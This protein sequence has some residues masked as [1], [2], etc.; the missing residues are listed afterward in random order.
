MRGF[1]HAED[2]FLMF[3]PGKMYGEEIYHHPFWDEIRNGAIKAQPDMHEDY[4]T[5][6]LIRECKDVQDKGRWKLAQRSLTLQKVESKTP[7]T[8]A[9][10]YEIPK[11]TI[12]M[13]ASISYSQMST[14][15]ACPMKWVAKSCGFEDTRN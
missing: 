7:K 10:F 2:H 11:S 5:A 6:C 15:I 3:Y 14:M 4:I 12:T 13:P 8:I 1:Q 9:A